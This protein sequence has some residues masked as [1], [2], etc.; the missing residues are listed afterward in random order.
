MDINKFERDLEA[1][2]ANP[3]EDKLRDLLLTA[4]EYNFKGWQIITTSIPANIKTFNKTTQ[5]ETNKDLIRVMMRNWKKTSTKIEI[6]DVLEVPDSF[7]PSQIQIA[8]SSSNS[9]RSRCKLSLIN[10]LR[11]SLTRT[12]DESVESAECYNCEQL[13]QA[14]EAHMAAK[15]AGCETPSKEQQDYMYFYRLLKASMEDKD[16]GTF[17]LSV[18]RGI[19]E[20]K[21][22]VN[23][24]WKELTSTNKRKLVFKIMNDNMKLANQDEIDKRNKAVSDMFTCRKCKQNKCSYYQVQT[25][26]ADEPMT[27]F[28][29]CL[30]CG[31]R[32]KE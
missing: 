17:V 1:L 27:T 23:M 5:D 14:I 18:L 24:D 3:D 32:W 26:S 11:E 4:Q 6:K 28:I 25:R 21:D 31:N 13:G 16:N 10:L 29:E 2:V 12:S 8:D 22:L 20:P 9:L 7:Y 15:Y 19:A 30:N